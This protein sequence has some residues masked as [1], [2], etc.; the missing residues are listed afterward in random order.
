MKS[1]VE[2]ATKIKIQSTRSKARILRI[3][4]KTE[5]D[6][7]NKDKSATKAF[8][9]LAQTIS[10]NEKYDYLVTPGG[11][12]HFNWPDKFSNVVKDQ[13]ESQKCFQL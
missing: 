1:K 4:L 12:I 13:S 6:L 3:A 7:F 11:F 8:N 5:Y 2:L 9:H 10:S